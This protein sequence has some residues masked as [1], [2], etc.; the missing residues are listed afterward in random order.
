ML[1]ALR[2]PT[3][4]DPLR[5]LVSGCLAGMGCGVNGTDYGLGDVL[6]D[7]L[8]AGTVRAFPYCPEEVGLGTP[9]TMPDI[10]GG[11][12][13]DV[14]DG[15][16][17]VLDEHGADLT[18][19]VI[20]GA[21]GMLVC[22]L[23]NRVE[24]AILTDMS[25]ACGTQVISDGCRLVEHRR[26]RAGVGV[27]AALLLRHGIGVVSQR[28]PRS[29]GILRE[30]LDPTFRRDPA[31]VDYHESPWYLGQFGAAAPVSPAAPARRRDPA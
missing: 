1:L 16:A 22:A 27:A 21:R 14:L 3:G 17:R 11:D 7:L 10:H 9:R 6:R 18:E 5:I 4:E 13:H 24:I 28:D 2:T 25:A 12:G 30:T 26:F 8:A 20:A 19:G 29:L 23:A 31:A 15:R